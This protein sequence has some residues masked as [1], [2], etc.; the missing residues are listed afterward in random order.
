VSNFGVEQLTEALATGVRI[1]S[2]ELCYNL[3]TRAIETGILPFCIAHG[4]KVI[5]YSALLQVSLWQC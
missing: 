4:I 3:L 2:N 5:A 1:A